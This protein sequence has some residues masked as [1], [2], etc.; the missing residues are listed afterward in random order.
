[1]W[2]QKRSSASEPS[3]VKATTIRHRP[4]K[5]HARRHPGT[6]R[7]VPASRWARSA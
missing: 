6:A 2:A 7:D 5:K 1:M 4:P 3:V